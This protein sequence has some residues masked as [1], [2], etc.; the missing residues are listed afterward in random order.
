[1]SKG[2]R[3]VVRRGG[4][5]I[6]TACAI[7]VLAVVMLL[8]QTARATAGGACGPLP[9]DLDFY[10]AMVVDRP[11]G[12]LGADLTGT[13]ALGPDRLLWLFGDTDWG[14][15]TSNGVYLP[16]WE[17]TTNSAF[18]QT[19]SCVE[20]IGNP[21]TGDR[22]G[23]ADA[24]NGDLY[25]PGSGW[26]DGDRVFV[27]FTRLEKADDGVF[28]FE[29]IQ[30]EL[31][32]FTSDLTP[33]S[34]QVLPD[35][36]R[37]SWGES[38]ERVDDEIFW[39]GN[40][41]ADESKVFGAK[42]LV[43]DPM[44]LTYWDG[45]GWSSS[46]ESAAVVHE[47]PGQANNATFGCFPGDRWLAVSV[48]HEIFTGGWLADEP[49]G[50]YV[51]LGP[52]AELPETRDGTNEFTYLATVH[53]CLDLPGSSG[54]LSVSI[55]SLE[56]WEVLWGVARN[57]PQLSVLRLEPRGEPIQGDF[58][59]D[60]YEDVFWYAAGAT[61]DWVWWGGPDDIFTSRLTT[62]VSGTYRPVTGDF[63]GDGHDDVFWYAAG[64]NPEYVWS[65][66]E[67]RTF[68]SNS[69]G[70]V[71]GTYAPVSG[72]FDGDGHD[73]VFWYAAG[74]NPEYVW[75]GQ[76]DRRFSSMSP[77]SVRG[78][79]QPFSGDFDGDGRKDV[80]WYAPG[81][82]ADF[83]WSGRADRGFASSGV[84]VIGTYRPFAGDFDGDARDDVF[85]YAPGSSRD[86]IWTGREDRG[87]SSTETTVFGTYDP[88][89][90]D[91]DLSGSDDIFWYEPGGGWVWLEVPPVAPVP[92]DGICVADLN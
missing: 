12:W 1:M 47:R 67:N 76:A 24:G 51:P 19:G 92:C 21:L 4:A 80:F 29:R 86:F 90:G 77:G 2:E 55:G 31:V 27:V 40:G 69:P 79:Y 70:S 75:S 68:D 60:G 72:D 66:T 49:M 39:W 62:N 61:P 78:T 89:V 3:F 9:T 85:W 34:T 52:I 5:P 28:G 54:L 65:G 83:V 71:I 88:I 17:R 84:S 74:S 16:G 73:D 48:D 22:V 82:S 59:G 38:L 11:D 23:L 13:V 30:N 25:W 64:S 91:F 26:A 81:S 87:F 36:D 6:K 7:A 33:V 57:W 41:V 63:D 8:P 50:P 15:R 58:D 37:F 32:E 18:L 46:P 42:S 44:N 35:T 10:Q 43:D 14:Q 56:R 20:A 45:A 53:H